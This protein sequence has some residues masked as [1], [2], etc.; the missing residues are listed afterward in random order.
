MERI[1]LPTGLVAAGLTAALAIPAAAQT[2]TPAGPWV[3]LEQEISLE[4]FLT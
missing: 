4:G 2:S 3:T 1:T